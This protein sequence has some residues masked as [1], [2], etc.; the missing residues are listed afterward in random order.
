MELD[1]F[2]RIYDL[3]MSDNSTSFLGIEQLPQ[4]PHLQQWLGLSV[5]GTVE[6]GH[7]VESPS[8][9]TATSITPLGWNGVP[10]EKNG[11]PLKVDITGSGLHL[12]T[13]VHAQVNGNWYSPL[14]FLLPFPPPFLFIS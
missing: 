6:L 1:L 2:C 9:R 5:A 12:C 4:F 14:S 8:I 10:G 11:E 3:C 13:L 7:I